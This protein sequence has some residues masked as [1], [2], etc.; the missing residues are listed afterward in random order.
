MLFHQPGDKVTRAEVAVFAGELIDVLAAIDND[1]LMID[2]QIFQEAWLSFFPL[3]FSVRCVR[4][5]KLF[6]EAGA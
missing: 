5:R 6:K 3:S 1:V 4:E 2:Q